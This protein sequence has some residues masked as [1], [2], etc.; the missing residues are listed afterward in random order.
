MFREYIIVF[1]F[2]LF[3][4]FVVALLFFVSF[5]SVKQKLLSEKMSSYECGFNPFEDIRSK[6]EVRY[7]M[8]AL[9][10]IIF[11][12]EIALLLP[13]VVF[14]LNDLNFLVFLVLIVLLLLLFGAF[15]FEW[16]K[17]ALEWE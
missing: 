14:V 7:F 4:F 10:F 15:F 5:F 6:F 13:L 12:L 9:L 8:V 1:Y 11:D 17:G 3:F 2:F 16:T